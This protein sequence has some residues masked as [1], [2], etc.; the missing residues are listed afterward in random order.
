MDRKHGNKLINRNFKNW[1]YETTIE[2]T[3]TNPYVIP[4]EGEEGYIQHPNGR[5]LGI[6]SNNTVVLE[7]KNLTSDNQ[8]WLRGT[9]D[10]N[11]WFTFTN[12]K[13]GKLLTAT[14]STLTIEGNP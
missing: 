13:S 4:N 5:V 12:P 3:A 9:L 14:L 2:T 10:V 1:P 6:L 8:K 7:E 11:E